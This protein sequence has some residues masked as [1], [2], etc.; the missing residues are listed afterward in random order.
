MQHLILVYKPIGQTPLEVIK[1]LKQ[2]NHEL[3]EEKISYAGRL[4]PMA[5]GLLLLLIGE[6]GRKRDQYLV[7]PKTYEFEVVFGLQ[8]D[9]YDLL[10]Y[11]KETEIK[12]AAVNV[13]LFVNTFVKDHIGKQWQLYP[14]Y[15]SKPVAGNPLFWWTKN[16]K[17]S[18]I[19]I[20]KHQIEIYEFTHIAMGEI[21]LTEIK[22]KT[23]LAIPQVHGDFRQEE[24]LKQW[25]EVFTNKKNQTIKLLT[26][27]FRVT[28]SSGTY[29]RE[30]ANQMG[31]ELG[32]GA[33][34]YDI[35][36]TNIGKYAMRDV[37]K[38]FT[39]SSTQ[40]DIPQANF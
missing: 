27:K 36:R 34:A 7:L 23:E 5:H 25:K 14:P 16:N 33:I 22:Q 31:Q 15:S 3:S 12:P 20:P 39:A 37:I 24:I 32:C 1:K 35:L 11:V 2:I 38:P 29:I 40:P 9:T 4:D 28:C 6:E 17:L 30:L 10:G 13:N 18:E 26:A 21:S 8:T 19:T